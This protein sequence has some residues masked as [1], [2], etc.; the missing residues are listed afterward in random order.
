[1]AKVFEN[2]YEMKQRLGTGAFSEVRTCI[3][4]TEKKEYAVKIISKQRIGPKR[5]KLEAEIEILRRVSGEHPNIVAMKASQMLRGT[6]LMVRE[7]ACMRGRHA[8]VLER[9]CARRARTAWVHQPYVLSCRVPCVHSHG[10][11]S[12]MFSSRCRRCS[13]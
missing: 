1:M 12:R 8:V 10:A 4:K 7:I 6:D 11:R 2:V 5:E 9:A 3:H 13:R